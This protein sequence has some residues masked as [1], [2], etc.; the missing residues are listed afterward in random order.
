MSENML[1]SFSDALEARELIKINVLTNAEEDARS[2]G[3]ELGR[4]PFGGVR[5]R[6]RQEGHF[7]PPLVAQKFRT[8]R[9]LKRVP[10][11]FASGTGY[12]GKRTGGGGAPPPPLYAAAPSFVLPLY[13]APQAPRPQLSAAQSF[14]PKKRT[15]RASVSRMLPDTM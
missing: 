11:V 1:R 7:V 10:H 2:L 6:H 5:R 8:H 3:D 15:S 9:I 14:L 12:V 4:P 13:A